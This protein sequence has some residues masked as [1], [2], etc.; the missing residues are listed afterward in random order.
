MNERQ[1]LT[2]E[3]RREQIVA[4]ARSLFA[5]N[6]YEATTTRQLAQS[7][8]VSDALLYRHFSGKREVL[9]EV[10]DRGIAVFASLPPLHRLREAPT[11]VLLQ[12]LGEGFLSRIESN[13]DLITILIS[14]SAGADDTR[15]AAFI[16]GA[17]VGL[18][19]ELDRR[20]PGLTQEDGYLVARS[21][22]GSLISFT[23]SQR[24]LGLDAI[25]RIEPEDYLRHLVSMTSAAL[26]PDGTVS[27]P[28][29]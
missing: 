24:M 23:I 4:A 10:V 11:R 12:L 5:A 20:H 9:D 22:F 17:A 3:A 15:F 2:G 1:R 27:P 14:R 25:R 21:F 18:G 6:G 16:D 29:S 13:L 7:V 28:R 19:E 26:P 8:G